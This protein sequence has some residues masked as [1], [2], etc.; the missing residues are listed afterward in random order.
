MENKPQKTSDR[1]YYIFALR[2]M[3]DF[4]ATI[5]APVIIFVLIGQYFDNRYG[6]APIFTV[7]GFLLAA[8]GSGSIIY[9]KA[10]K[11]GKEFQQMNKK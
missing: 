5:A 11:Y 1:E 8:F 9:K 4:G 7:I 2:I 6:H 3:G 10:K